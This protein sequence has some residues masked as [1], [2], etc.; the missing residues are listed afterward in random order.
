MSDSPR[1]I[2]TLRLADEADARLFVMESQHEVFT[3]VM[4]AKAAGSPLVT[5]DRWRGGQVVKFSTQPDNIL[6]VEENV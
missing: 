6:N 4:R 2:I 3:R 1:S 5:F